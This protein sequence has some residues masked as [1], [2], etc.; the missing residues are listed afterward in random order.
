MATTKKKLKK[1]ART[2]KLP[3]KII[4]E[5]NGKPVRR[6]Q[7]GQV[8]GATYN[9]RTI[10]DHA[11]G[12]LKNSIEEF[13]LVKAPIWNKRTQTLVGGHQ[14]L[15][16]QN[17]DDFVDV[18]E[19]DLSPIK[20]K[21]LNV[22]LNNPHISGEFT[23]GLADLL[24]EV[25]VEIPD[26]AE[27]LNLGELFTDVPADF[28]DLLLD[29]R[30]IDT[31]G[32]TGADAKAKSTEDKKQSYEKSDIKQIILVLKLSEHEEVTRILDEIMKNEVTDDN[33]A[34]ESYTAAVLWLA[35]G[36]AE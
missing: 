31:G 17:P 33:D 28:D 1:K 32:D 10:T 11:F 13:G 5:M 6:L 35:R 16:T 30:G 18:I 29:E 12:G 23:A 15:K 24:N 19:V 8:T 34:I 36:Y 7:V 9:P 27:G 21:A 3:G 4:G 20:E 26:L 2:K 22:A 25:E 14:R